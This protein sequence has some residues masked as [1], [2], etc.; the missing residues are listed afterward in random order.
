ML[1]FYVDE[2][3]R[4]AS[5]KK[6]N[7]HFHLIIIFSSPLR[8]VLL[9]FSAPLGLFVFLSYALCLEW[10]SCGWFADFRWIFL[11]LGL[12]AHGFLDEVSK[13]PQFYVMLLMFMVKLLF[14]FKKSCLLKP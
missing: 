11:Q 1:T 9:K 14:C 10:I 4:V 5:Y 6:D 7:P 2:Y 13:F 8:G 12:N 3:A